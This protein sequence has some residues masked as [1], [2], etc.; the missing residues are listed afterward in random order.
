VYQLSAFESENTCSRYILDMPSL[1]DM[2]TTVNTRRY[3]A[4]CA[5]CSNA[6]S[7]DR[8]FA[9]PAQNPSFHTYR[10]H[11]MI[12]YWK[13]VST[14]RRRA[15]PDENSPSITEYFQYRYRKYF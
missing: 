2:L 15:E 13:G 7:A 1:C 11:F 14:I 4:R 10:M 3:A 12:W 6:A 9:D 5:I 8:P